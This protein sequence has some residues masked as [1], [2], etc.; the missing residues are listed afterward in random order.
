MR[1]R[2]DTFVLL[3]FLRG[4][5]AEKSFSKSYSVKR[6]KGIVYK[7]PDAALPLFQALHLDE[8]AYLCYPLFRHLFWWMESL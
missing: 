4:Y 6:Q 7:V 1:G 3:M 2:E 8:H 5:D